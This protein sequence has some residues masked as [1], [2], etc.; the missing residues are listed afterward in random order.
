MNPRRCF[1]RCFARTSGMMSFSNARS[2]LPVPEHRSR[3]RSLR[4]RHGGGNRLFLCFSIHVQHGRMSAFGQ[5]P[6]RRRRGAD[7]APPSESS[8]SGGMKS[9]MLPKDASELYSTP[10]PRRRAARRTR[11]SS[12]GGARRARARDTPKCHPPSRTR[13]TPRPRPAPS[14]PTTRRR[15][16][17]RCSARGASTAAWGAARAARQRRVGFLGA[18][19]RR[20]RTISGCL[21][22]RKVRSHVRPLKNC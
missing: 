7:S 5:T 8:E 11:R 9:Q 22:I 17:A 21:P 6:P 18:D 1:D 12:R 13:E 10:S 14:L 4:P 15:W 3:T 2:T 19:A 20:G 16:C